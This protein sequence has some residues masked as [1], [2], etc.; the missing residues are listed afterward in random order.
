VMQLLRQGMFTLGVNVVVLAASVPLSWAGGVYLGLAG[1]AAGSVSALYVDRLINLRRIAAI[2]GV[3]V[4]AQQRWRELARYV[5]WAA[6]AAAGAWLAVHV[7]FA[8]SPLIMRLAIG[9]LV[10]A[11]IY[12]PAH[13]TPP[14][15][16]PR[17]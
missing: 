5:A 17:P 8:E 2:S 9:F 13:I 14:S 3:P 10:M 1:A 4:R 11:L 16:G 15:R 12:A 6:V 7:L